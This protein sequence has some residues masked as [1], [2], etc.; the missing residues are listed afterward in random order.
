[1][2]NNRTQD[3]NRVREREQTN[4]QTGRNDGSKAGRDAPQQDKDSGRRSKR[5]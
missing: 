1:M 3:V 4:P 2:P 5:Q